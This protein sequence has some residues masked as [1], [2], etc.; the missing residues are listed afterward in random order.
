[1]R[2]QSQTASVRNVNFE[3]DHPVF[4]YLIKFYAAII[5]NFIAIGGIE[6]FMFTDGPK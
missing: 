6:G 4:L 5:L 3:M 2:P 1:M